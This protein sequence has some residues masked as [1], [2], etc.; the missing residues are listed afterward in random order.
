MN[1][2]MIDYS[3]DKIIENFYLPYSDRA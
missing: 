1:E 3:Q 2:R